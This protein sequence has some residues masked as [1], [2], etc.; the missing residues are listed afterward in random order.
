MTTDTSPPSL[1]RI[2]P[3]EPV[4]VSHTRR[5]LRE[6]LDLWSLQSVGDA[7]AVVLSE[8]ATNAVLHAR[9]DFIV[10]LSQPGKHTLH[11]SVTDGSTRLPR[12]TKDLHGPG[13]RGLR[14]IDAL[15]AEWG[16]VLNGVEGKTVWAL[17]SP[18]VVEDVIASGQA[19][20][21]PAA[22]EPARRAE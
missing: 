10:R 18:D 15:S 20:A 5:F 17:V 9:T 4:S 22:A 8:L 1:E 2:W 21:Q 6:A 16:A 12:W 7:A 14:L 3:P 11:L 19:D 13:G